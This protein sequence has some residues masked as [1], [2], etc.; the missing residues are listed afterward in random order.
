[1]EA[2]VTVNLPQIS[3]NLIAFDILPSTNLVMEAPN[4]LT[5][6]YCDF[7]DLL[8]PSNIGPP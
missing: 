7:V 2:T 8:P 3:G 6:K 5:W 1:M 4:S